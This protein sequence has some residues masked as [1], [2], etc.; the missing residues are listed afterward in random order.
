[1]TA[2]LSFAS[3]L[4]EL[5]GLSAPA[6]WSSIS[7]R[8]GARL[9]VASDASAVVHSDDFVTATIPVGEL[10]ARLSARRLADGAVEIDGVLA[11]TGAEPVT[12]VDAVLLGAAR[13]P[14]LT[15]SGGTLVRTWHGSEDPPTFFPPDDFGER[16][17]RLID[18]PHSVGAITIH[19]AVGG[20][21]SGKDMPFLV[22]EGDGAAVIVALEWSGTW[23]MTAGQTPGIRPW[24]TVDVEAGLW[25]L[26]LTI[27]PGEEL[28]IPRVTVLPFDPARMTATN[29]LRRHVRAIAPGLGGEETVPFTSFNH[30]FAFGND[31]TDEMLRPAV[32]A[33]A[34]AG[35]EYFVV[36]A[37]WFEGGYR[38]G[39]GNWD[40]PDSTKFPNGVQSFSNYVRD[41]DMRFGLWFEPEFAHVD[42]STVRA[43]PEWFLRGP[44]RSPYS[45]P[46]HMDASTRVPGYGEEES[47]FVMMD[48]GL[49]EVQDFWVD[50]LTHAHDEW[51]VRWVRWDAN[52]DPRAYWDGTHDPGWAQVRHVRGLYAVHDRVLR[53][54]P[55][56]VIEQ[57]ASGGHRI[58][59]GLVRRSHTMW[60]SDHTTQS[61]IIR[62]LQTGLNGLL[63]GT[64]ANTN[65]CQFRHD[66]SASDYLSHLGGSF[67]YSG[68]IWEAPPA[69]SARLRAVVGEFRRFRHLLLGDFTRTVPSPDVLGAPETYRWDDGEEWVEFEFG[70]ALGLGGA[71]LRSSDDTSGSFLRGG[72][73]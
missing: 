30:W 19:G 10:E 32:V 52:Q 34:D 17:R 25:G 48:F 49:A 18:L 42:S 46:T 67:G 33:C 63:T 40:R 56:L 7:V 45:D 60:M 64:Y 55:D 36:D 66:Y 41:R 16:T 37:G 29:A 70:G 38:K 3:A 53:Q 5:L 11:N 57:C 58:D 44:R 35:I 31:Y 12:N 23:V 73:S 47:E 69:D 8:H 62:R 61:D 20:R 28:P 65:L 14:A 59:L 50:L 21:S 51:G 4:H 71:R 9:Q 1:M 13:I 6:G 26:A 2:A 72:A 15:G 43:H 39:L 68:R 54:L 22:V 27:A 24:T